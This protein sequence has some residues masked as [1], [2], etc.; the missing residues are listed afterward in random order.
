M[1]L[2]LQK[3]SQSARKADTDDARE[4]RLSSEKSRRL[5]ATYCN[6][7]IPEKACWLMHSKLRSWR[8]VLYL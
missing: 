6:Q 4:V 2:C 1:E 7:A 5:P 3:P 8:Q